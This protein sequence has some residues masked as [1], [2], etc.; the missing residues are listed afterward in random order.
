M[1]E[2]AV[3]LKNKLGEENILKLS[4]EEFVEVCSRI[5]AL[6]D[7]CLRVRY[8]TF[9]YSSPLPHMNQSERLKLLGN[10]LFSQRSLSGK[11]VLESIYHMLY[12]GKIDKVPERIWEVA[13]TQQWKIS[14][15]GISSL[16]EIVGWA[17]PDIYP[18]RNGRTSKALTA[19]GYKVRI[20]SQ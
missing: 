18:P 7:H 9:G 5:H 8:S 12:D 13:Q 4:Q 3:Y 20:H 15:L 1:Y 10:W 19:L 11:S 16:G 17:L 6:R 14:H 2:W